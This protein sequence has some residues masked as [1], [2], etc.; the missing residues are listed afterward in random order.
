MS[1]SWHARRRGRNLTPIPLEVARGTKQKKT[2]RSAVLARTKRTRASLHR[3]RPKKKNYHADVYYGACIESA[4]RAIKSPTLFI[5]GTDE[6]KD[7][8]KIE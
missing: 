5:S 7:R 4:I 3:E 8:G 2:D 1:V 6:F